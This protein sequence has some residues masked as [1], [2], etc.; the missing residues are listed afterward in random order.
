MIKL[1]LIIQVNFKKICKIISKF[2]EIKAIFD[3]EHKT[4]GFAKF[5]THGRLCSTKKASVPGQQVMACCEVRSDELS[6]ELSEQ[7][8][9][10]EF[11][12]KIWRFYQTGKDDN[13]TII[14]G[15]TE[16]KVILVFRI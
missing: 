7:Q 15:T 11:K 3:Q 1:L 14:V 5:I 13:C 2:S 10:D 6:N 12:Q 8:T 9:F 4:A 16:F